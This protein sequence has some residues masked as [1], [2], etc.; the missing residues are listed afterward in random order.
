MVAELVPGMI[1]EALDGREKCTSTAPI[2]ILLVWRN[3]I[4][5]CLISSEDYKYT[6]RLMTVVVFGFVSV[7]IS[8]VINR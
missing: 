7:N 5:A 1:S 2:C 6:K 4:V 8:Y 3:A